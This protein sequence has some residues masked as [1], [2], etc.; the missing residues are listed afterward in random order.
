MARVYS[1]YEKKKKIKDTLYD[2]ND[3]FEKKMKDYGSAWRMHQEL[4]KLSN[5]LQIFINEDTEIC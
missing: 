3:D 1:E 4:V 2:F 5:R